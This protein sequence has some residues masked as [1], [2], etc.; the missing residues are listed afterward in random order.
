MNKQNDN[1]TEER[2]RLKT[3]KE[4]LD[5]GVFICSED[6]NED[7]KTFCPNC[8]SKFIKEKF[9]FSFCPVC[10]GNNLKEIGVLR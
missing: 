7:Y 9:L 6:I 2:K 5:L 1:T 4:N 8:E 3:I 10:Q